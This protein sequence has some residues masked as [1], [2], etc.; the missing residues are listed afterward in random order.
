MFREADADALHLKYAHQ[1][2]CPGDTWTCIYAAENDHLECMKY[3]REHGCP[4]DEETL[5]LASK[6]EHFKPMISA[7]SIKT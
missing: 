2:E 3:A 5:L 7:V 4:C 1:N 6:K